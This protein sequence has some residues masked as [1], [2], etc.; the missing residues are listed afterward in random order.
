[1]NSEALGFWRPAFA[2]AL[3]APLSHVPTDLPPCELGSVFAASRR[4]FF[5]YVSVRRA[6][7]AFAA[8]GPLLIDLGNWL[9]AGPPA[10]SP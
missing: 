2:R 7:R 3:H 1:M 5:A 10:E 6:I 4:A 9:G 8:R